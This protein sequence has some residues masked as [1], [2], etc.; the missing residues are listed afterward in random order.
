MKNI[1]FLIGPGIG[2]LL[3]FIG[4]VFLA[5]C[6]IKW[7]TKSK[8]LR[9]GTFH[10]TKDSHS[11]VALRTVTKNS[12]RNS[13]TM[14][15]RFSDSY[16]FDGNH[17]PT[18]NYENFPAI[19]A[20]QN[21]AFLRGVSSFQGQNGGP[22]SPLEA[23]VKVHI[24][25]PN[26][27]ASLPALNMYKVS[28]NGN[29]ETDPPPPPP[30]P[31]KP[32]DDELPALNNFPPPLPLLDSQP[33]GTLNKQN[34]YQD[35]Y[36][37]PQDTSTHNHRHNHQDSGSYNYRSDQHDHTNSYHHRQDSFTSPHIHDHHHHNGYGINGYHTQDEGVHQSYHHDHDLQQNNGPRKV[38]PPVVPRRKGSSSN[39][40]SNG[41]S[42]PNNFAQLHRI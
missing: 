13:S 29:N 39:E 24:E 16:R 7:K 14:S 37:E 11:A 22:N 17:G 3:L 19:S 12:N 9:R 33:N 32:E 30:L 40:W 6:I 26:L 2:V 10:K 18:G 41:P 34:S 23:N 35:L 28:Q 25:M 42:A 21:S 8:N 27:S 38:P 31:E 1:G 36:V 4:A 5:C 20:Q 15:R